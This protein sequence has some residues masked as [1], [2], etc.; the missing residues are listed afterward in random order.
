MNLT[1]TILW[2][3]DDEEYL[4]SFDTEALHEFVEEQGFDLQIVPRTTPEDIKAVVDGSQY[5]LLIIDYHIAEGDLHGS[6]VIR[7]VRDSKCLTEVIFY[8]QNGVSE[9]RRVA[10]EKELEGVFYSSKETPQLLRKIEDVFNLTVRKVVDV[11]NMRGIVMAGV[12]DL[13]HLVTDVIRAVHESLDEGKKVE[14]CRRLLDRMRPVVK[15]LRDLV[16]DK[17]HVHFEEVEKL[18]EAVVQLDPAEFETLVG[19][20]SFDSSRRV[21]MAASLCK[22]HEP[23]KPH[24]K[25]ILRIKQLLEWRN[26]LAHQ[27]PKRHENGYPVFE[28]Q[29]GNEQA[30]DSARTLDLRQQL[31]AQR[32]ALQDILAM[33]RPN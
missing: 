32:A 27:R 8:S 15:H 1:Y 10:A 24:K 2:I 18:I 33:L 11:E 5:D 22:E 7:Q 19:A 21:D 20:R 6:D 25:G 26:A 16:Q 13:D 23:L 12:A 17:D 3:E 30:F 28:P 31:R 29:A 9:L 4:D 14:L